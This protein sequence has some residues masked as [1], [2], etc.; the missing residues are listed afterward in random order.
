[1]LDVLPDPRGLSWQ[2]WADTVCGFNRDIRNK[3][4]PD[5]DWRTFA[6]RLI[7]FEPRAPQPDGFKTWQDWAVGVRLALSPSL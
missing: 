2:A 1:M 6:V 4:S 3:V 5:D 7:Q